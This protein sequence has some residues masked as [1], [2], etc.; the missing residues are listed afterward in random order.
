MITKDWSTEIG[1]VSLLSFNTVKTFFLQNSQF[2]LK[3][4]SFLTLIHPSLRTLRQLFYAPQ[5]I[6]WILTN[7]Q[8][9]ENFVIICFKAK[10]ATVNRGV[11][12]QVRWNYTKFKIYLYKSHC[13]SLNL[14]WAL[15]NMLPLK[16]PQQFAGFAVT[17]LKIIEL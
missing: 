17:L 12:T 8:N 15:C 5:K 13:K 11:F 6:K 14:L 2:K 3:I 1:D 9:L 16:S 10:L 7:N 4:E